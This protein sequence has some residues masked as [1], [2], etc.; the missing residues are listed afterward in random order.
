[1]AKKS[2]Y[3]G[4]RFV[5]MWA[6]PGIHPTNIEL[7]QDLK[8]ADSRQFG[9]NMDGVGTVSECDANGRWEETHLIGLRSETWAPDEEAQER[10]LKGLR[11]ER[12]TEVRQD[13]KRSGRL[14]AKQTDELEERLSVDPVMELQSDQI[15]QKRLVL[16]LFKT[17]TK[18]LQ[19]CGT[20][21]EVTSTEIHN[22]LGSKTP[23]LSLAVKLPGTKIITNIQQNHRTFRIPSVFSFCYFD[24][25][26]AHHLLLQRRWVSIGADYDIINENKALGKIDSSLFCIGHESYVD[27]KQHQLSEDTAFRDLVTLFA[28]SAGYH[29]KMR[30]SLKQ[31][32]QAN[33]AGE[34]RLSITDNEELQLYYN[35]RRAA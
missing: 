34:E 1:M 8:S 26:V 33:L 18:R 9:H 32:I 17:T 16:K 30:R 29:R 12:R 22:S 5:N 13:I 23:L 21:E 27:F 4:R 6:V 35:G 24:D 7:L 20:I 3:E 25:K 14:N 10:T 19:W 28:A 15:V 11:E 2:D 31:R